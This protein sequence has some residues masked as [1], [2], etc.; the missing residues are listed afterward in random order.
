MFVDEAH[1][2]KGLPFATSLPLPRSQSK[3]ATDMVMKLDWLRSPVR[4]EGGHLR[5]RH[6]DRQHLA[7]MWV[8]QR[9]LTPDALRDQEM[10]AFD[11][12][13]GTFARPVTRMELPPKAAGS[14]CTP[15][16]PRSTTSPS[17]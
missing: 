17:C 10:E 11:S 13:A 6:P 15:A 7:E 4:P 1:A 8:L 16:S 3:R 2:F 12:W 5:H 9:F 14:G